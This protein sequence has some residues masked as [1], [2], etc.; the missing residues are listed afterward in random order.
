MTDPERRHS[1]LSELIAYHNER[2]HTFDEPEISDAE[3]DA[4]VLE[5]QAIEVEHPE[6]V[7]AGSGSA[8]E[9]VGGGLLPG[10]TQ[11]QHEVP[12]MSLDKVFSLEDLEAWERR[13]ARAL[14][15]PEQSL[16]ELA[17]VCELKIDG[18]SLSLRYE[19]GELVRA[20]TRGNGVTGED[21]TANV[22][23][24]KSIPHRLALHPPQTPETLEVRGELYMPVHAFEEL[25]KRQADA[26][27]RLFANPRNSAAGSLRQKDP[28]VT[29]SR[30][31]AFWAHQVIGAA[32]LARHSETLELLRRAGLPVNPAIK[33][34]NGIAAV[35]DYCGHWEAHRHDLEYEIDGVVVKLDDL[36]L[37]RSVGATS[38][39]PRWA[40]AYKYPP[41]ERTTLLEAIMVSIGRSGRA[42]PFAKLRPVFVG[43]STVG[44][45]SLHNE[46][47]VRLKDLRPGDT[48]VV[49]KAGDVIPEVVMPVISERP[50]GLPAWEFPSQCPICHEPLVRLPGEADT[51]CTNF[52]CPAQRVQR[53]AHFASRGAMDIE[54]LGEQRVY[55]FVQAGLLSDPGDIFGLDA[56][57]LLGL[58]GFGE[59]S[60]NNLLAAIDASKS[61]PL[62]NVLVG[63][64]IRHLGPTGATALARHLG[65][66]DKIVAAPVEELSAIDSVGPV[67]AESVRRYFD[68][69]SNLAV[70]D[71]LRRAGVNFEG[72]VAP[73]LPQNLVGKS[74]VVTG[75][76][77][78]FSRDGAEDAIKSRGGKSP[79]SVSAKTTALVTGEGPGASKLTKAQDLGVP[80]L[81]E[82]GF[83]RLLETGELP[84]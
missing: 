1:E 28:A 46:D 41:E 43:G 40:V 64:G 84:E 44:L 16:G 76:L 36:A 49:R 12:M 20:A 72:P 82:D 57:K 6:L 60:V 52:E 83:V 4:L 47:Q 11:V 19:K 29:A 71:K 38:H 51:Y 26:D 3:F 66:L 8:A 23:T 61:R 80:I 13:L 35:H 10:F 74:I 59:I 37:Q 45:A 62:A 54:G 7:G 75:T 17:L 65:S 18:L 70:V 48:V 15:L 67:I 30:E 25:N 32:G 5:L 68:T 34:V 78:G 42:T 79:G 56:E 69:D 77:D 81:D 14:E 53:L 55:Q 24:V 27:Q 9:Q 50:E 58:E 39:A 63:L 22:R 31:L 33:V 73:E 21:V 2:Y